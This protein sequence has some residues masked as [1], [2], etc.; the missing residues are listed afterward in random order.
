MLLKTSGVFGRRGIMGS[1]GVVP[2]IMKLCL[3]AV[4]VVRYLP[5]LKTL[6]LGR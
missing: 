4:N 6:G 5:G 1:T 3:M 2:D